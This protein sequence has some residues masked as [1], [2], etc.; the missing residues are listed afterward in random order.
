MWGTS[1]AIAVRVEV[2]SNP[3]LLHLR[4]AVVNESGI[5]RVRN[6]SGVS[7]RVER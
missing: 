3:M 4:D 2:V 1:P 7:R 6:Q 5:G